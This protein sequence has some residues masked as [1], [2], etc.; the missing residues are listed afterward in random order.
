MG[1]GTTAVA[2]RITDRNYIGFELNQEYIDITKKRL[3]ELDSN[4][5]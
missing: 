3:A 4:I 1:S 2:C 5:V